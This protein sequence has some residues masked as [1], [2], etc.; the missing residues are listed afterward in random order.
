MIHF[1][2]AAIC[3]LQCALNVAALGRTVQIR[4]DVPRLDI[5]GNIVHVGDGDLRY[6]PHLKKFFL[7]GTKYQP[8][9]EETNHNITSCYWFCGWR[10]MTYAVYSSNDLQSWKLE[11]DDALPEVH[12]HSKWNNSVMAFFEPSVIYN[13]QTK[14]YVMWFVMQNNLMPHKG[15]HGQGCATSDSPIGPFK[16]EPQ[17]PWDPSRGS[18]DLYLW[19]D[20]E[21]DQAYMKHNYGTKGT[22]PISGPAN[23][24]TLLSDDY[25]KQLKTGPPIANGTYYEG[26]G[27]FKRNGRWYVTFGKGCCFCP[28]GGGSNLYVADDPLGNWTFVRE[29]NPLFNVTRKDTSCPHT[30]AMPESGKCHVIPAQQFGFTN[31]PLADGSDAILYLGMRF[32]SAPDRKKSHDFQYWYKLDFD[33][34]GFAKPIKWVDTFSLELPQP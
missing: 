12:S 20:P 13:K 17:T 6:F 16:F 18:A 33:E 15:T 3:F 30:R 21:T 7:Y 9:T 4:N 31:V 5:D 34:N 26:G 1:L 19:V 14:K 8:C 10:N 11:T 32:G 28:F 22:M 25:T 29:L 27:I 24:V 23:Y 2:I